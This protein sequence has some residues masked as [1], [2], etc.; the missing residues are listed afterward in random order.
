VPANRIGSVPAGSAI[1]FSAT[2]ATG[3]RPAA[4][5]DRSS[6]S[7]P[8]W[9]TV[10][11]STEAST[12]ERARSTPPRSRASSTSAAVPLALSLSP[13][14]GA[15]SSRLATSTTASD[16]APGSTTQR[17][18]IRTSTPSGPGARKAAR[19]TDSPLASASDP[20]T[21]WAAC[22][23][24]R[25]PGERSGVR[26]A[27]RRAYAAARG[28][29]KLGATASVADGP[30]GVRTLINRI[31]MARSGGTMKAMRST[32]PALSRGRD[33]ACMLPR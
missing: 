22:C 15:T 12:S 17:F 20:A 9:P 28:P 1:A 32:R 29:S 26:S 19:N 24:V 13:G 14:P 31:T 18:S 23:A 4:R 16:D 25:D 21:C 6:I 30:S 3:R 33:T 7:F 5:S 8:A 10:P 11:P 2:T 27:K